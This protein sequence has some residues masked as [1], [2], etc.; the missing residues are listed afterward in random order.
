MFCFKFRKWNWQSNSVRGIFWYDPKTLLGQFSKYAFQVEINETNKQYSGEEIGEKNI[1]WPTKDKFQNFGT[2]IKQ[3]KLW[4]NRANVKWT[5]QTSLFTTSN[6]NS[7]TKEERRALKNTGPSSNKHSYPHGYTLEKIR[8]IAMWPCLMSRSCT[9]VRGICT[10]QRI[11]HPSRPC[12]SSPYPY[13]NIPKLIIVIGTNT[14]PLLSPV[15]TMLINF[16]A[17]AIFC[18][19]PAG[20]STHK[21]AGR[22]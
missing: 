11:L 10:H 16:V 4:F 18:S 1:I 12:T 20:M 19:A 22:Q 5:V 9:F 13:T 21:Q 15:S 7:V 8:F 3:W 2:Y 17:N 14:R 6:L